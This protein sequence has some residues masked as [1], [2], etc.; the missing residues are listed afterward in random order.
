MTLVTSAYSI[1]LHD[2]ALTLYSHSPIEVHDSPDRD[3][4][5]F[6]KQ[7][8]RGGERPHSTTRSS[9]SLGSHGLLLEVRLEIFE[10]SLRLLLYV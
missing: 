10:H 5:C 2:I 6:S 1:Y 7:A 4:I 9:D 3:G 8:M